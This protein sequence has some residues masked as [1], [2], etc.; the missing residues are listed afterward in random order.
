M[1]FGTAVLIAAV[2]CGAPV[3]PPPEASSVV[4]QL[5]TVDL[6]GSG[7][8]TLVRWDSGVLTWPGGRQAIDGRLVAFDVG[9]HDG[10]KEAVAL[11]FGRS[12]SSPDAEATVWLL[13]E[14]GL[15]PINFQASRFSDVQVVHDGVTITS[16][17][18]TKRA[19][20]VAV[21]PGGVH[22][23]TESIMGLKAR[24]ID[25]AGA[26]AV[27]RLYGDK[28]RSDG[29]LEIHR[30]GAQPESIETVR[31][32][33]A[34]AVGDVDGDGHT[35]LVYADGW[36]FRYA[37]QGEALLAVLPGPEFTSPIRIGQVLG[38]YS[39]DAIEVVQPGQLLVSATSSIVLFQSTSLGWK[40]KT[41]APRQG[42]SLP[43]VWTSAGRGLNRRISRWVVFGSDTQAPTP[44]DQ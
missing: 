32:V 35:D 10:D 36:H 43:G 14:D 22:E 39:I 41:L 16:V 26:V 30:V 11:A 13:N 2:G 29:G 44:I 19:K 1:N 28:P 3:P 33:R 37:K 8:D 5:I 23:L 34:L 6:D 20:T 42:S 21:N 38:S 4:D 9:L 27:G 40:Q 31:G 24:R 15:E 7:T 25:A 12:K 17:A 18:K